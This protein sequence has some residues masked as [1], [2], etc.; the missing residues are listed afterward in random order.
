M[1]VT[2]TPS[3]FFQHATCSHWLWHDLYTDKSLK[4]EVP[5]LAQK[6]LEQGV[7][8]EA[9]FIKDLEFKTI[10]SELTGQ[11]G[12]MATIEL[13]QQGVPYIYQGVLQAKIDRVQYKGRPDLLEKRPGKSVFGNYY[14]A[15]IDIKNSRELKREHWMQLVVYSMMLAEMQQYFPKD[16]AIINA[17][18][19]RIDFHINPEHR[20]KTIEKISEIVAIMNGEKPALKL[21][22]SCKNSPWFTQCIAEAEAVNDIALIY[23]LDS[24]AMEALRELGITTV[25]Q[26]ATMDINELPKIPYVS[27]E[28]LDRIKLQARSL[29]LN[30]IQ[31][32]QAPIIPDAPLKIYFDIEGDPLLHIEYLFGFWIV[33]DIA[34]NYKKIGNVREGEKAGTYYLYFIAEQPNDELKMWKQFLEWVKLLPDNGYKIYH[35]ADYERTRSAGLANKYG[36]A[37]IIEPFLDNL[38]DLSR[39]VQ[40]SVIFPLYFYSIKDIAKSKFLAYKWRHPKAGGAQSIFWYEKWLESG[41]RQVLHDIVNYNEDDVIATEYLHYW[42]MKQTPVTN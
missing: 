32:L 26:A 33:G 8:H 4:G 12:V 38:V 30:T 19:L 15:P 31:W 14:Y 35:F 21:T 25:T 23:K 5:E 34:G 18:K 39:V 10:D 6:L 27:I 7:L 42:L 9:D 3:L 36:G 28:S 37:D 2:F 16:V 22:S 1:N 24:R 11:A 40:Q 29:N 13:M 41:D 20:S 17:E